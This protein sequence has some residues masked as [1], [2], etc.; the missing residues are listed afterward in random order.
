MV[1]IN[2][3]KQTSLHTKILLLEDD[4]HFLNAVVLP[5]MK[6]AWGRHIKHAQ[7]TNQQYTAK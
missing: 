3:G 6:R 7:T 2:I 4:Y 1:K 5:G